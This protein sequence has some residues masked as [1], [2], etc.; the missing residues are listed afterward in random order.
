MSL[1]SQVD[2]L[3]SK[4]EAVVVHVKSHANFRGEIIKLS[5]DCGIC[6]KYFS[7]KIAVA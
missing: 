6:K 5:P 4:Y 2:E 7:D 3:A 1:S